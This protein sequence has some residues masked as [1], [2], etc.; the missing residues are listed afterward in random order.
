[1][2]SAVALKRLPGPTLL[3]ALNHFMENTSVNTIT[4]MIK[5]DKN[6]FIFYFMLI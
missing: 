3:C 4:K 2:I 6:V 5:K 1:M